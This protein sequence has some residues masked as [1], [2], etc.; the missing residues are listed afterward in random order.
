MV[1]K[2]KKISEHL[3]VGQHG[4]AGAAQLLC[5]SLAWSIW[6]LHVSQQILQFPSTVQKILNIRSTEIA[7]W[8]MCERVACAS[9]D[10]VLTTWHNLNLYFN[11]LLI[12]FSLSLPNITYLTFPLNIKK[13]WYVCFLFFILNIATNKVIIQVANRVECSFERKMVGC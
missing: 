7:L 2:Q 6:S 8:W 3:N 10:E 5:R 9:R 4:G 11:C 1:P 12:V 13:D